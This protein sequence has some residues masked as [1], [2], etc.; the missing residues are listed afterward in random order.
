[1][2]EETILDALQ[3][4]DVNSLRRWARLGIQSSP[5]VLCNA[6][7]SGS[8][9]VMRCL[10]QDFGADINVEADNGTMPLVLASYGCRLPF[11][12][13]LIETLGAVG[14]KADRKCVTP[15]YIA[16]ETG[17]VNIVRCLL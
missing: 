4:G 7:L 9:D 6:V 1:M 2:P 16:A 5:Y 13:Y 10:V 17:H 8:F 3:A 11:V 15:L 12:R 14:N